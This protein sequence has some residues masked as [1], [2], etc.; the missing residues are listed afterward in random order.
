MVDINTLRNF[1]DDFFNVENTKDSSNNG[2]QVEGPNEINK[3]GLVVDATYESFEKAKDCDLIIAHHGISWGDSLKYITGL[4]FKRVA[5]LIKNNM[6]LYVLHHPLDIHPE[7]GHGAQFF[8]IMGWEVQEPF[9]LMEGVCYG[10]TAKID[11]IDVDSLALKV[12]GKLKTKCKTYDY[13]KGEA[14]TVA[15]V[16]GGGGF[17]IEEAAEKGIDVLITG[18]RN[19]K[20]VI[21]ARDLGVSV[22]FA[23]HYKT[24][25]AGMLA[26]GK[27]LNEKFKIESTFIEC[28]CDL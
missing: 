26:L 16:S 23:G 21:A 14:T 19:H 10:F 6:G 2:L 9:G 1:L 13:S 27:M 22:I 8:K 25:V 28:S 7:L 4:N 20:A 18:E 15:F 5:Y 3:V 12:Q 24:E 11:P 17:C